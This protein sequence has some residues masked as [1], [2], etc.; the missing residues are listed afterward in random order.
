MI[1]K[2]FNGQIN[3]ITIAALL[4]A[5][6]SLLSRFLGLFRDRILA[7]QFGAGDSLDSFYAA[8][9]VPDLIFNLLILGALSAGFIP[10][11]TSLIKDPVAK[12]KN[13]ISGS[14]NQEAWQ[15]ANNIFNIIGACL[16][17]LAGVGLFFAPGLI[18]LITP[19]FSPHKQAITV[20]LTRIMFLSPFFLGLSSVLGGILQSFKRFFIY[21][22][23]PIFYNIGIIIGALYLVPKYGL[24]GL[25][26]GVVLGA[27]MHFA[28]QLPT[29]FS[30]GFRYQFRFNVRDKNT[31]IIGAMSV[32]RTLGLATT[33]INLTAITIIASTLSSGSLAIF[34]FA[35]NLQS[36][37]I[38]I[39]GLSFAVAAFPTLSAV[40][41]DRRKLVANFS[42]IFRQI[43]FFIVPATMLLFMLRAQIIRAILGTGLFD[44]EDTVLTINTLGFFTI[45]IFAQA[46]IP[47]LTRIFYARHNSRTPFFIGLLTDLGN[48]LIAW[49][50]IGRFGVAGLALSFSIT[51][52]SYFILLWLF[53]RSEIGAL[54]E[55][56]I[57]FSVIKFSAAALGGGA[58]IQTMKLL[59]WPY[60]DMTTLIGILLQGL[61]AG[62]IGTTVYL[63]LCLLFKSEELLNFW[64][65]LQRRLP[66][67]KMEAEDQGE[68]RGI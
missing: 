24:D 55:G 12:I 52:I 56:K 43:L 14:P 41:F 38:G 29:L 44:W 62:A 6:S 11:F 22:L 3:S 36:F 59:I 20:H 26:W 33:Q 45:S 15:L 68:A 39:F 1:K 31:R 9:R 51:S 58:A 28:V 65:S 35:N 63:V 40:A 19:G 13:F 50:L 53:L 48:I 47:L 17:V 23:S 27:F 61:I 5:S 30:L 64:R 57:L 4:V 10:L 66:W 21:S 7:G 60:V 8:F 37:P 34:N 54:D 16:I 2:L 46:T 25:A 42:Y 49:L 67:R 32:P 18:K